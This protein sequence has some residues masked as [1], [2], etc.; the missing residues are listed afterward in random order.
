MSTATEL[1]KTDAKKLQKHLE[2]IDHAHLGLINC[3]VTIG[4]SLMEIRDLLDT[5]FV[6]WVEKDC[7]FGKSTAYRYMDAA[8][9]F[10]RFPNI[11]N[12]Q[13]SAL[14]LLARNEAAAEEAKAEANRGKRITHERAKEIIQEIQDRERFDNART[15]DEVQPR[16]ESPHV[17]SVPLVP[18]SSPEPGSSDF[19]RGIET[20]APDE[21][22]APRKPVAKA[23]PVE[24]GWIRFF[25]E[26]VNESLGEALQGI[27][28]HPVHIRNA[29]A[30]HIKAK[31]DQLIEG[32]KS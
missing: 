20:D 18:G 7:F 12:F 29:V 30:E 6:A 28:K 13:D 14:Y 1:S 8:R 9:V 17:D 3:A 5:G 10:G 2:V 22:P 24:P 31:A 19:D 11:G 23:G 25:E 27:E 26:R 15:V 16:K 4:T 21:Q 32:A